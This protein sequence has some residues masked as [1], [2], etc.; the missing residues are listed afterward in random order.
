[1]KYTVTYT[2]FAEYQLADIWVRVT[3]REQVSQ[4][5]S[6]IEAMLRHDPEQLGQ[7]RSDGRRALIESPLGYTFEVSPDDRLVKV[8]S[9]RYLPPP[10]RPE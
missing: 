7:V 2:P 1:M 10:Q 8:V 6:R 9:I 3:D 5:S 4:A